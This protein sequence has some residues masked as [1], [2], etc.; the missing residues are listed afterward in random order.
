MAV[1]HRGHCRYAVG[2]RGKGI[3]TDPKNGD[4]PGLKVV[5]LLVSEW[6]TAA[7]PGR[8]SMHRLGYVNL[9]PPRCFLGALSLSV[10]LALR[11]GYN[12][13][14]GLNKLIHLMPPES[15]RWK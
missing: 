15:A 10:P 1:L 3:D 5:L 9:R 13:E 7:L 4:R 6:L 14:M 12:Y 8:A 2:V 11:P